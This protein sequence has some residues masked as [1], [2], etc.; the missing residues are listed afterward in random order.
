MLTSI[1]RIIDN[2]PSLIDLKFLKAIRKELQGFLLP[3]LSIGAPDARDNCA[4]L[5]AEDPVM[6]SRR[7]ELTARKNRLESVQSE[8]RMF[9]L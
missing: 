3:K 4:K 2:V 5:L 1:Q 9:G 7:D 8:L 6:A